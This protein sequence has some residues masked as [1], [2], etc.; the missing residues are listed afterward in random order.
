MSDQTESPAA[1]SCN[2][3]T[4]PSSKAVVRNEDPEKPTLRDLFAMAVLTG[5]CAKYGYD[6][7][8]LRAAFSIADKCLAER[9]K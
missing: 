4:F 2:H 8:T 9:N 1:L 6:S 5:L 3:A 7:D